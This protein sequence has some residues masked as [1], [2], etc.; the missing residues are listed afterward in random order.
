ME[1]R[2]AG[3]AEVREGVKDLAPEIRIQGDDY[4]SGSLTVT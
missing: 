2:L 4:I 3:N 1:W